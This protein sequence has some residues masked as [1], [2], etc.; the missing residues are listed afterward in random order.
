[1][2]FDPLAHALLY[3]FIKTQAPNNV[4]VTKPTSA[5]LR[6][7]Q[8]VVELD[9]ADGRVRLEVGELVSEQKSRHGRFSA[10]A[11]PKLDHRRA[12]FGLYRAGPREGTRKCAVIGCY[13]KHHPR[14]SQL[15]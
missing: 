1:M 6:A 13:D 10:A 3:P 14:P 7:A 11:F 15:D 12:R 4:D 5:H 2:T 8:E 9:P